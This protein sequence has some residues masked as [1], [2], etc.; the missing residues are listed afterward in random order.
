[1]NEE[2]HEP[3]APVQHPLPTRLNGHTCCGPES[4]T[5]S[6]LDH[7]HPSMTALF[8]CDNG[9]VLGKVLCETE[10]LEERQHCAFSA[11]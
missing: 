5:Q 3:A 4:L 6:C 2:H 1:M 11:G 9:E 7:A 10:P 8:A